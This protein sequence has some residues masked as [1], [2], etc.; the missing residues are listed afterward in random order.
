MFRKFGKLGA[1]A[2]IT[3]DNIP[4]ITIDKIVDCEYSD[5]T[6]NPNSGDKL[7]DCKYADNNS[8]DILNGGNP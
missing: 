3:S 8:T 6:F 5:S 7:Y 4:P 2:S 1:P